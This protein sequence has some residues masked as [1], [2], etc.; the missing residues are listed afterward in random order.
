MD[1]VGGEK[2]QSCLVPWI[3][4][5]SET[6]DR[7]KTWTSE[8]DAV[9]LHATSNPPPPPKKA[10]AVP[11]TSLT[12]CLCTCYNCGTVDCSS[13]TRAVP[14]HALQTKLYFNTVTS[15]HT[16]IGSGHFQA[17][18]TELTSCDLMAHKAWNTFSLALCGKGLLLLSRF[19]RVWLCVTPQMATHQAP[20]PMGFSRQKYWSGVPLPSPK[21]S[22]CLARSER[23]ASQG[24]G[25]CL[26]GQYSKTLD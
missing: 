23:K 17:P 15:L 4:F 21:E 7:L 20:P 14:P 8:A 5:P 22:K 13:C 3:W 24:G 2:G 10:E 9:S 19:S 18:E 26:N 1:R 25:F 11:R 6:C 12:L 16:H